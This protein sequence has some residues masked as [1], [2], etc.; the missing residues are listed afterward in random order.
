MPNDSMSSFD[1]SEGARVE[2]LNLSDGWEVVREFDLTVPDEVTDFVIHVGQILR[3]QGQL[4]DADFDDWGAGTDGC[5]E[6]GSL[7]FAADKPAVTFAKV[8]SNIEFWKREVGFVFE[9]TITELAIVVY[10]TREGA[11]CKVQEQV[12]FFEGV[13]LPLTVSAVTKYAFARELW[14]FD[15]SFDR[16]DGVLS[17]VAPRRKTPV[18][19]PVL[20]AIVR[21]PVTDPNTGQ[22]T[23]APIVISSEE[24]FVFVR[25]QIRTSPLLNDD[26][27]VRQQLLH[28]RVVLYAID[29]AKFNLPK[30]Q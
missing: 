13:P 15:D 29:G 20:I 18:N 28:E 23:V 5:W 21:V 25:E 3:A 12:A 4:E 17:I 2:Q 8:M 30:K 19:N 1:R 22:L 6:T 7:Q 24:H 10:R 14:T 9:A 26:E 16:I 11:I 27:A